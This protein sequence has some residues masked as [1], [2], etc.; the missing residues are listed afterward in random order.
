MD[1]LLSCYLMPHPPIIIS[2]I[3]KGEEKKIQ[4]TIDSMEI[5][6][7]DIKNKQP[8]TIILI[9]PHGYV[10]EDAVSINMFQELKGDMGNF[11]AKQ[12][13]FKFNNDL[14]LVRKI[15]EESDKRNIPIVLV[16]D[17]LI[18]RYGFSKKLDHGT[19]VPL[20]FVTKEYKNFKL[21]QISYGFLSFEELYEFGIALNEAL[22]K[23]DKKAV[24]IA[25][26]DLSHKLTPDS[27]NGYTPLGEIFDK[28]LLD[29]I[30]NM[31][32]KE[33]IGMDKNLIEQAAECGFRSL[34]ILLGAL[35]G[36]EVKS[37]V[38]SHEGP[39]GVGYGVCKFEIL[40]YSGLSLIEE[41]H[42]QK[43]KNINM[44]RNREDPY[45][46]LAR[47]SLE[48]FIKNKKIMPIPE[49][50]PH[51]FYNKKA[52]VFVTIHKNGK[53]RGCIGTILP[54]RNNIA[55][56]II[57]NA[58]SSGFED[59]R[60]EPVENYELDDLVYSVDI[61]TE[62]EPVNSLEELN[63]K[64]YGIIVQKGYRKGLLLPNLDGIETVY[65]QINIA[66][67]KAGINPDEDYIIEKFKVVRH[68]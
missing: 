6:A 48:Y 62:P 61:L 49:N 46:K 9:T 41:L 64:E 56:E 32:V 52:G 34:C 11:G 17:Q 1:K 53:L 55:E 67:K 13:E 27:P 38:L 66:L 29:L 7:K 39:F 57:R 21:V 23:S 14:D 36:Y 5:V 42:K 16:E 22:R 43:R 28:K 35:D 58:V 18:K 37:E 26:G 2:E 54:Q 65:D 59:P 40:K 45:V 24:I 60:F 68:E 25:S 50:L 3:G 10:F 15:V 20:N 44:M 33:I 8:E 31:Q 63:P 12:I 4:K 51:E 19:L 30:S 47:E